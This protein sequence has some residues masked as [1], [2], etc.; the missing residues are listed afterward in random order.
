LDLGERAEKLASGV[1]RPLLL[2]GPVELQ[3]PLGVKLALELGVER[4]I[5]DND[6]RVQI[7]DA[8]LRV[9]RTVVAVDVLPPLSAPEWSIAGALNDLLQITNHE[10]S[11]FASRSR[12]GELL[13]S[14]MT[15]CM[16]I[17][18]CRTLQEAV[19][20]HATF[21]RAL[22]VSRTDTQVS[23][24][25]GSESF[26]GQEPP[27]RLLAWPGLRKVHV[28]RTSLPLS[29]MAGGVSVAEAA[30]HEL[31]RC[32]LACSPISDLASAHRRAPSFSW[33]GPTVSLVSTIAGSNLALRALS[34][35][36]NDD[37]AAAEAAIQAMTSAAG[38]LPEGAARNIAGQFSQWMTKA[39]SHWAEVS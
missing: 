33:S 6:L 9:A 4:T 24:W 12:H 14:T 19:A 21:A 1:L 31:L 22:E 27:G 8:R 17:P 3:R 26:R 2:G 39:K 25:T 13:E 37:A 11:T 30:F 15:L 18:P 23:W 35:A 29:E 5:V 16:Q 38:E 34:H 32:W 10:L 7:D 28:N 36:T 20:R